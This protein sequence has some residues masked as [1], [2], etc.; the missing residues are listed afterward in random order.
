[1]TYHWRKADTCYD[2]ELP[3]PYSQTSCETCKNKNTLAHRIS[4]CENTEKDGSGP[5]TI[6]DVLS[7]PETWQLET[8]RELIDAMGSETLQW[9]TSRDGGSL[10]P[11][12]G[13][14]L[15]IEFWLES[16]SRMTDLLNM[17]DP[18]EE[19]P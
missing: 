15:T 18:E 13:G 4:S 3:V 19:Q 6:N 17:L 2:C 14:A 8:L 12:Y 9:L 11:I 1:M 10:D 5:L 16:H 7:P